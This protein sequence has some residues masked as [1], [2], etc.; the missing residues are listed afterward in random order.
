MSEPGRPEW[1]RESRSRR[2]FLRDGMRGLV[3][4]GLVL[5][6]GVLGWRTVAGG[7]RSDG[8]PEALPCRRCRLLPECVAPR[9]VA[10]RRRSRSGAA[11]PDGP[12]GLE[13]MEDGL[14]RE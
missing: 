4:G 5:S 2:R 10:A 13:G 1:E 3:F 7:S 8:C 12:P 14:G 9:A 11:S 6:G